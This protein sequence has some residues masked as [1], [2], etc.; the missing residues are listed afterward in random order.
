MH[1]IRLFKLPVDSFLSEVE[2]FPA[3]SLCE[4]E[5]VLI[6]HV[7]ECVDDVEHHACQHDD[8]DEGVGV[9]GPL[10]QR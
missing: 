4:Q 2:E 3:I 7:A 5:L 10:F 8:D 6:L 9:G 1:S